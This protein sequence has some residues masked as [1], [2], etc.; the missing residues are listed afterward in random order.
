MAS[1]RGH[2]N[3]VELLLDRGAIIDSKDSYGITPLLVAC[4]EG[5]NDLAIF[6]ISKGANV[7]IL[8]AALDFENKTLILKDE[9]FFT[10]DDKERDIAHL[11]LFFKGIKGK[12]PEYS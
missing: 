5:Y 6:L 4:K 8:S 3:V 1:V 9:Q 11:Q 12:V 2:F 7:P 10:T